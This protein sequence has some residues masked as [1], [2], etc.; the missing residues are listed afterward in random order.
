MNFDIDCCDS[1]SKKIFNNSSGTGFSIE[2]HLSNLLIERLIPQL[3]D[4]QLEILIF[5]IVGEC[6][7]AEIAKLLDVSVTTCNKE[8]RRIRKIAS[9]TWGI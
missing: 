6:E 5:R 2:D 7:R 3:T 4:R 1:V 9:E 8:F